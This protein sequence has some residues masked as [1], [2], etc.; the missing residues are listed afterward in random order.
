MFDRVLVVN[1]DRRPERWEVF[2]ENLPD[3]WPFAE[4]ERFSAVD[5][6]TV[7]KPSWW[8]DKDDAGW[9]VMQTH[10]KILQMMQ[11]KP[12][13]ILEDDAIFCD[14]F[15][16]RWDVIKETLP[17]DWDQVYLGG[18]LWKRQIKPTLRISRDWIAPGLG[19]EVNACHAV[20]MRGTFCED[21]LTDLTTKTIAV[22]VD[23][24]YGRHHRGGKYRVYCACPWLVGQRAGFSDRTQAPI[25]ELWWQLEPHIKIREN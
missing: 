6:S 10:I 3:P 23:Y 8:A 11:G 22:Q 1:L 7:D 4:P 17:D 20:G 21:M 9:G 12:V 18:N 19:A 13:L 14:G 2:R 25:E 5:G 16:E 24:R 15:A